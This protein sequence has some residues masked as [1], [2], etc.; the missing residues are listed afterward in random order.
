MPPHPITVTGGANGRNYLSSHAYDLEGLYQHL[1]TPGSIPADKFSSHWIVPAKLSLQGRKDENVH[2]GIGFLFLDFD[3]PEG[4]DACLD[5]LEGH[6]VIV[7]T[8]WSHTPEA[9]RYR[10]VYELSREVSREENKRIRKLLAQHVNLDPSTNALSQGF[11]AYYPRDEHHSIEFEPGPPLD[12]EALLEDA[13]ELE[14]SAHYSGP[15]GSADLDDQ[16]L[17]R[18]SDLVKELLSP[19]RTKDSGIG[20][21]SATHALFGVLLRYAPQYADEWKDAAESILDPANAYDV[22]RKL[23]GWLNDAELGRGAGWRRLVEV[24]G[25]CE[26]IDQLEALLDPPHPSDAEIIEAGIAAASYI[27]ANPNPGVA[28][29]PQLANLQVTDKNHIKPNLTNATRVLTQ[30]SRWAGRFAFNAFTQI[31]ELDGEAYT[32]HGR[33]VAVWISDQYEFDVPSHK[34]YEAVLLAAKENTY[35]PVV[36]YLES[37]QWDGRLRADRWLQKTFGV[38]D[39]ALHRAYSRRFLIA[40]V[41]RAMQPGCK[42][43]DILVLQGDQGIGKSQALGLLAGAYFSDNLPPLS[44]GKDAQEHLLG[45]WL[46][47]IA[48]LDAIRGRSMTLVKQF[49]STKIDNFRPPYGRTSESFPRTVVFAGTTN[50]EEFLIDSTGNRRFWCVQCEG[51]ADLVWLRKNRDQLFAEAVQAYRNGEIWY[52]QEQGLKQEREA[53]NEIRMVE[54]SWGGA[55]L[56]WLAEREGEPFQTSD[57]LDALGIPTAHQTQRELQ[58]MSAVLKTLGAEKTRKCTS[59]GRLRVW[60]Y[61]PDGISEATA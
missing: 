45:K 50:E 58:R 6:G 8:S 30:D 24:Y 43:D 54:D 18:I 15:P 2:S 61:N 28:G 59:Q 32:G 33:D 51:D 48:E 34:A 12:V 3:T 7:Y 53:S 11:V 47:E 27:K 29:P 39:T 17:R 55:L 20:R 1:S 25:P 37:L 21:N 38:E 36:E 5:L 41:A 46:V 23:P 35:N 60:V 13:P 19:E 52:I 56:E 16:Q 4:P 22:R 44:K 9:P 49:L 10:L 42:H 40:M 14:N 31:V 26:E 57:A